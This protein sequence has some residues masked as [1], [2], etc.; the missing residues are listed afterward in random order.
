MRNTETIEQ[1]PDFSSITDQR[2]R[3]NAMCQFALDNSNVL[4]K[5]CLEIAQSAHDLAEKNGY[6][7]GQSWALDHVAYQH[8]HIGK[9]EQ[10]QEELAL[11][12]KLQE[13]FGFYDHVGWHYETWGM[14]LWSGGKYDEAFTMV[15][16]GIRVTEEQNNTNDQ[17]MLFWALGVFYYDLKDYEKSLANYQKAMNVINTNKTGDVNIIGYALIGLG[18]CYRGLGDKEKALDYF[19]QAQQK[20]KEWN[21][22]MQEA[23][24]YYEIGTMLFTDKKLD[25]AEVAL[26]KSYEMRKAHGTKPSMVS[27]LLALADVETGREQLS[28]AM[29]YLEQALSIAMETN[30]KPKIYQCHEK[31]AA[32]YKQI[33]NYKEALDHIEKFYQLRSEVV[34]EEA[35]NKLKDLETKYATERSEK[36]AEIQRL[37]NVELKKAHDLV[38]EK[39]KEI[40]DSIQ[41][42]KRIQN[43]IL[44]PQ[45]LVKEYLSETFILYKP[46]DIV[47]GDFYWMDRKEGKVLFA[48]ADC[49]GHGVPGALVS[50][51]CNNGLNRS[52][53]EYGLT[54]PGK[55]LDKTREIVIAEFEKSEEDV[56]DGMDIALCSL[57]LV[58]K[59]LDYAGANNPLYYINK[60]ELKEI[61]PDKQPIGKYADKHPYTNH[62]LDIETGDCI[63]IFSDGFADQ[64][65]GPKGKK[66]KYKSFRELLLEIH[67]K[68]MDE[69]K[70]I[71]DKALEDW[72]G[73]LD[74]LDDIC[75]IGLRI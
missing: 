69:Q 57:D 62:T 21:H 27:S 31:L 65:G 25:E 15:Y 22:W 55:I 53:R 61:K 10:A 5:K 3:V 52:V 63:Y 54:A 20:S 47:A 59:K 14:I 40:T 34:G 26:K 56:K 38:A 73:P 9:V 13:E 4:P 72:K 12:R 49:T 44:P 37:R 18:C 48:A 29:A 45:K 28:Q 7:E 50:V 11:S 35:S 8:W 60:G 75:V 66:F 67:S 23:R 74:Q 70:Q 19:L 64:F 2:E 33:G 32:Q 36:E 68:P 43:A 71:L 41:Y 1:E 39:N 16:D 42:A 30:N 17:G 46:K 6:G 51:I 24:T 58:A